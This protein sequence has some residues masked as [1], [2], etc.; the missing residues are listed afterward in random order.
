MEGSRTGDAV[1]AELLERARSTLGVAEVRALAGAV[2]AAPE[3]LPP[4]LWTTLVADE[5][6]PELRAELAALRDDLALKARKGQDARGAAER[7]SALRREIG[8]RGLA[9]FVVPRADEHQGEYVPARAERLA[10]LTGFKGSAGLAVV[11]E[12]AAAI[13]VDGRYTLQL[14]SE[15]D[16][17]LFQYRY[18]V[19]EPATDWIAKN[20]K[21]KTRLGFDPWL[22]TENQVRR[23][24]EACAG[25]GAE[26][27]PCETNPID[28]IWRNQPPPPV[29]P[30]VV[31][32]QAFAGR[33]SKDK[34]AEV[35]RALESDRVAAYFLAAPGSLA[36]LLNV[37]GGDVPFTPL[38]LAFGLVH[39]DA[40]VDLFLDCRKLTA[41]VKSHLANAVRVHDTARLGPAFDE[42]GAGA[43]AVGLD[44]GGAPAWA[45]DRL[46]AAGA[47]V[48][49]RPDP[50]VLPKARKN[51]VELDGIRAAHRRDGAALTRFLAWFATE[52]PNGELTEIDAARRLEGL[53]SEGAHFRGLSFPTI[54]GAGP[55]GAIVHYRVSEETNRRIEAGMLYLVD[56]GAQYLDGTTDVTRTVAIGAP[57]AEARERFTRVLQGHI[58]I[59][60]TLFPK[61]TSGSQP[62]VLARRALWQVGLDYDHG[63]GHGVG[64]YLGVHEGPQRIS[65]IGNQI[66][67]EPGMIVSNEPGYYKVGHFGIRIENL[68]AVVPTPAP[69]GAEREMLAFETLT[70][71]PIDLA[72][73]DADRLSGDERDWLNAYHARVRDSLG[74]IVDGPTAAWLEDATRPIG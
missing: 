61:G 8:K 41:A 67:L 57:S 65:K 53:R 24:H 16:A 6:A 63:T 34:R 50:C 27:V 51:P 14:E 52:A 40:S 71:A 70:Q 29:A 58:A 39:A 62:D 9:G 66:A 19:E 45:A 46:R 33:P 13:F 54:S 74:A 15:V 5:P 10:W 21:P 44:A 28:A 2:N 42:L 59:A 55:N 4:D 26:L 37:R 32:D 68:V 73:V 38:A 12:D 18:L 1:L 35:V 30:V 72:L 47:K 7:L 22:H 49:F 69:E 25:A 23:F 20:L 3:G 36:W 11:L 31:H 17:T 64:S 43:S 60:T 48:V 56:S